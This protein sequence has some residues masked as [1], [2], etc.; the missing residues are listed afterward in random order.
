MHPSPTTSGIPFQ[1][2]RKTAHDSDCAVHNEPAYPAG[3]C[4]CGVERAYPHAPKEQPAS[5]AVRVQIIRTLREMVSS[6]PPGEIADRILPLLAPT[7]PA[8]GEPGN[9]ELIWQTGIPP[10][11]EGAQRRFIVAIRGSGSGKIHRSMLLYSNQFIGPCSDGNEPAE[12]QE[13]ANDDGDYYWTGWFEESCDQ[14]DTFW[15]FSGDVVAWMPLPA[16]PSSAALLAP[17][18]PANAELVADL[19]LMLQHGRVEGCDIKVVSDAI[20]AL[21]TTH[22][23]PLPFDEK[24]D[25]AQTHYAQSNKIVCP[26]CGTSEQVW[27]RGHQWVCHRVTCDGKEGC[28]NLPFEHRPNAAPRDQSVSMETGAAGSTATP[29]TDEE[30]F[31]VYNSDD[32][33]ITA[34]K[35]NPT[36][37]VVV[38]ADFA[39]T[40]EREITALKAEVE[41]LKIDCEL[42][43]PSYHEVR[44]LRAEL[45]TQTERADRLERQDTVHTCHDKCQRPLCVMRREL[46]AATEAKVRAEADKAALK[47]LFDEN[48]SA[49]WAKV[50]SLQARL[51]AAETKAALAGKLAEALKVAES[52]L[53]LSRK[54]A[55]PEQAAIRAG[56]YAREVLAAYDSAHQPPTAKREGES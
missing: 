46:Q 55:P 35:P 43:D 21:Q 15:K 3:P 18:A 53:G 56:V 42:G 50:Q 26:L 51:T 4:D 17:T 33:G 30:A 34:R 5:A 29:R 1:S 31:T 27:L 39:R 12:G 24:D 11:A 20:T 44:A 52:A 48:P 19:S 47:Q 38:Y 13:E 36:E 28:L 45:A 14:C 49:S 40:L 2:E 6:Y 9:A 10:V 54:Y 7:A 8:S 16:Y 32:D 22:P 25:L 23:A 41:R 37:D